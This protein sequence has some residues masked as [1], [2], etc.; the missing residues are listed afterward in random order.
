MNNGKFKTGQVPWNKGLKGIHHS[1]DT[2]FKIDGLVG[3]NHPSWKGGVQKMTNDCNYIYTGKNQRARAP[4]LI[5][6]EN[7][8]AIPKG[9]II[10]HKDGIKDN[11]EPENLEAISRGE[12]AKRNKLK[13]MN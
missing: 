2:E 1:P 8:G 13:S 9:F 10:Y 11:D 12:L 3:E 4:R 5:Y 7:F 6:E